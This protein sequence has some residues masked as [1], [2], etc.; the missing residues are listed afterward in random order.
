MIRP[1]THRQVVRN[2]R[3]AARAAAEQIES[4][5]GFLPEFFGLAAGERRPA[6][7]LCQSFNSASTHLDR[8]RPTTRA[9]SRFAAGDANDASKSRRRQSLT[10]RPFL[11]IQWRDY[12]DLGC[13]R[14]VFV[15]STLDERTRSVE[16]VIATE[17][18][19][20]STNLVT[21]RSTLEV[22]RIDG[23][24]LPNQ[25]P[26]LDGHQRG[27]VHSQ[28]GSIRNLRRGKRPAYR[29]PIRA[30]SPSRRC[31]PRSKRVISATFRSAA[32]RLKQPPFTRA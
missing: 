1:D 31:G 16:A 10:T 8:R 2:R 6:R 23:A 13:R 22:L 27:S 12:A 21:R 26:L 11:E 28:L 15:P 25:M 32:R 24:I 7:C 17:C 14:A 5:K 30:R 3:D 20:F 29:P 19:A 4:I 9:K 18:P